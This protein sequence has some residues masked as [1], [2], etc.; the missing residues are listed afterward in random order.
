MRTCPAAWSKCP[1]WQCPSAAP[2][3][4]QGAPG[5]SGQLGTPR[6]RLGHRAS[7]HCLGCSS[8]PPPKPPIPPPLSIQA[9][10]RAPPEDQRQHGQVRQAVARH[11]VAARDAARP[12]LRARGDAA[13][14]GRGRAQRAQ[15]QEDDQPRRLPLHR[16]VRPQPGPAQPSPA[17][18]SPAQ[19]RLAPE[20]V[21][22]HAR[23]HARTPT[24]RHIPRSL[25]HAHGHMSTSRCCNPNPN[26]TPNQVR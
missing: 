7:S 5:G 19:P 3:R 25:A 17:Q 16:H 8:E 12:G 20:D 10:L 4:S 15:R 11:A 26:P 9:R 24:R 18:P 2:V 22:C 13:A 1:P 23:S 6:E 14:H 21:R